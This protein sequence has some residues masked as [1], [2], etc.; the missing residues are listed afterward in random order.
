MIPRAFRPR[1]MKLMMVAGLTAFLAGCGSSSFRVDY[2]SVPAETTASWRVTDVRVAVPET[3][4]VSEANAFIPKADIVWHGDPE[5]DRKAQVADIVR[6]GVLAGARG[7]SGGQ[8]VTMDVTLE[9]FHALTPRAFYRSPAWGGVNSIVFNVTVRDASGAV[10]IGPERIEADM[11]AIV[12][13]DNPPAEVFSVPG[14]QSRASLIAH[15]AAVTRAWLNLG[16]DQRVQ[17]R[18]VGG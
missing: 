8:K 15:V 6:Q 5:G 4:V 10:L 2:P 16:P 18:R 14:G 13:A 17:I 11:P 7:L 1:P 9:R 12:A 3:L